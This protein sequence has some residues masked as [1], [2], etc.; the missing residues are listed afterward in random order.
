MA[1]T[2]LFSRFDVLK[3]QDT[4]STD[5]K[6]PQNKAKKSTN[7]KNDQVAS[8]N[9][10]K[11]ARKKKRQQQL[12]SERDALRGMTF[13]QKG[14]SGQAQNHTQQAKPLEKKTLPVQETKE[15]QC[16]SHLPE[17][18][19][20]RDVELLDQQF[21]DDLQKALIESKVIHEERKTVLSAIKDVPEE[22]GD[23]KV[24]SS[25]KDKK[26]HKKVSL[27]E[28][29]SATPSKNGVGLDEILA[30]EEPQVP[31][32]PPKED[33]FFKDIEKEATG[34][35]KKDNQRRKR[36]SS[37]KAEDED[38]GELIRSLQFKEELSQKDEEITLLREELKNQKNE[39]SQVKKR[40]KQ[41]CVILAQGEM[42]DKA[43]VLRQLE[44]LTNVK[45][46]LTQEVQELHTALEQ[47]RSKVS[48][49]KTDLQKAQEKRK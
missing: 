22:K 35:F 12:Q 6:P 19:K 37:S 43:E 18:W 24:E 20:N 3:V 30:A 47:E 8:E 40:N 41:L 9:A 7:Q 27:Q 42:K 16:S 44:E 36:N 46:E 34:I 33:T 39:L 5:R 11:R 4:V 2:Q 10:K 29:L 25:K 17:S 14:T 32:V 1:S 13:M 21:E 31:Q 49:L 26:S 15:Q 48:S 38:A 45:D 23:Q 28:F